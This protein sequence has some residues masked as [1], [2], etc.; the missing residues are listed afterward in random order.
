MEHLNGAI[1]TLNVSMG[2][3]SSDGRQ[4]YGQDQ[5]HSIH[6]DGACPT[7]SHAQQW[8]LSLKAIEENR[9]GMLVTLLGLGTSP[10]LS[11]P[12]ELGPFRS[13]LQ[14]T[15]YRKRQDMVALLLKHNVN[16]NHV[17]KHSSPLS[18]ADCNC[19]SI[20]CN[21]FLKDDPAI[22]ELLLPKY[23]R[24]YNLDG[25]CLLYMACRLGAFKCAEVLLK[26]HR[27]DVNLSQI[28]ILEKML[29]KPKIFSLLWK[30]ESI[31]CTTDDLGLYLHE[32]LKQDPYLHYHESKEL[33]DYMRELI[34]LGANVNLKVEW[35]SGMLTALD[36]ALKMARQDYMLPG[37][38]DNSGYQQLLKDILLLLDNG[39]VAN[40]TILKDFLISLPKYEREFN[41]NWKCLFDIACKTGAFKCP[42]VIWGSCRNEVNLSQ[43]SIP[44]E[45][46]NKQKLISLLRETE[47]TLY[48]PDY[49]GFCLHEALKQDPYL[50]YHESKELTDYM[51][52]L[53]SFGANVN[54]K[55]EWGSGMLTALDVALKMA[56]QDY[57]LPGYVD[58]S[59]YQQLLKDIFLLLDNGGVA[60][61]TILKDFLISTFILVM[62]RTNCYLNL[63][64]LSCMSTFCAIKCSKLEKESFLKPQEMGFPMFDFP[65]SMIGRNLSA[66]RK[67]S[68]YG[69]QKQEIIRL[70]IVNLD[71][72]FDMYRRCRCTS[73]MTNRWVTSWNHNV[74]QQLLRGWYVD[75]RHL[76][77]YFGSRSRTR[78]H[79]LPY[80][81]S[82]KDLTRVTIFN[83]LD[84]P[85][86]SSAHVLPLPTY[87][88]D[89]L[90]LKY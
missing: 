78:S 55:V 66:E 40:L 26:S 57:M 18:S 44:E 21:V 59:G 53:I 14:C 31:I 50:H 81:R 11:G 24:D 62:R 37:Y 76:S 10:D 23:D 25:K 51:R 48:T 49:L 63:L 6:E 82:L 60:K 45:I 16:V 71:I 41:G 8:R 29:N 33:T 2:E 34:S 89:Y 39:G 32:A 67:L 87:L 30:T 84:L 73:H 72:D 74:Y 17:L 4:Q 12:T 52:E 36:V 5:N 80:V 38:V 27:N 77:M 7:L 61:M 65:F 56:R 43:I 54:L 3:L 19:K 46:S 68:D 42:E 86:T 64:F 88:K 20:M 1:G 58:N 22:M 79:Q 69:L 47:C 70:A 83:S 90:C 75:R 85:R 35:G 9:L 15:I 13:L 28:S